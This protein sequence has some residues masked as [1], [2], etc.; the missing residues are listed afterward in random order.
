MKRLHQYFFEYLLIATVMV[1]LITGFWKIYL[2]QKANPNY[3]HHLHVTINFIWL[4]LLL[5]Q[6][7]LVA[8]KR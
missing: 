6:L 1:L 4:C 5:Y 7:R 8:S 3:Y 2:G